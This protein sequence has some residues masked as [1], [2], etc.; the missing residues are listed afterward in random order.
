MEVLEIIVAKMRNAFDE[1][2]IDS[3]EL[4]GKKSVN[5]KMCQ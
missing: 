2:I 5:L 3:T 1:L 4:R